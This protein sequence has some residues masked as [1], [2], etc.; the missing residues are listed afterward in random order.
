MRGGSTSTTVPPENSILIPS[1]G[2]EDHVCGHKRRAR[3]IHVPARSAVTPRS[4]ASR[5]RAGEDDSGEPPTPPNPWT[6]GRI[7]PDLPGPTP[8]QYPPPACGNAPSQGPPPHQ[9]SRLVPPLYPASGWR[10]YTPRGAKERSPDFGVPFHRQSP[11][12][13]AGTGRNVVVEKTPTRGAPPRP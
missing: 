12:R 1:G 13:R 6:R 11:V 9:C 5:F 3:R 8:Y 10:R 7:A 2:S 4:T